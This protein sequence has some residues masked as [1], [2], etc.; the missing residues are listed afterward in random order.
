METRFGAATGRYPIGSALWTIA[1]K[2]PSRSDWATREIAE[3]LI[4]AAAENEDAHAWNGSYAGAFGYVQFMP[5]SANASAVDFDGDGRRRLFEWPDALGSCAN[6]LK[7]SGYRAGAPFTPG[8][9]IGR[10]IYSY[11]HSENYVRVILE[12]RSELMPKP[13]KRRR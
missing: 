10:A 5:S 4:F 1:R 9:A 11:N 12:L 2:V 3:L 6:Y 7:K 13:P 8:S